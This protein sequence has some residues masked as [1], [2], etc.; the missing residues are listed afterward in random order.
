MK[1]GILTFQNAYNY[2]AVLQ[3][4]SLFSYLKGEFPD[5]EVEVL[6]YCS[7]KMLAYYSSSVIERIH[8][9][10]DS[11]NRKGIALKSKV[12]A[13]ELLNEAVNRK[14]ILFVRNRNQSINKGLEHVT[15]SEIKLLSSSCL[16][17]NATYSSKYDIIIVGSD[18]I[19]NDKQ[20][21]NPNV[22]L[23][24][25]LTCKYK[26]SFAASMYGMDYSDFD[27]ARK[28]Y[29]GEALSQFMYIGT[30]DQATHNYVKHMNADLEVFHNC[31]PS[32]L[33]DLKKLPIGIDQVLIKLEE[34]GID[35]SK[36]IIG[37][38]CDDWL[39]E[40]VTHYLGKKYQ[41]VALYEWNS[42]SDFYMDNLSPFEWA[43][44][45]SFF[46]ATFTHFFHGTMFSLKNGTLTF[47]I[48][49][50]S[51]Y[52]EKYMTKIKDALTRMDLLDCYFVLEKM[53]DSV[54]SHISM[55]TNIPDSTYLSNFRRKVSEGI[56][57]ERKTSESFLERIRNVI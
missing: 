15:Q 22:Y 5:A 46:R 36:P 19:W 40:R 43:L 26:M 37:L 27:E 17:F 45:F 2:G 52:S 39:A 14:K 42:F 31:D 20:V 41:Y 34:K 50:S 1:I 24:N 35:L 8:S 54:W 21:E 10:L 44:A 32:L 13:N 48:E 57:N 6:D 9:K 12:I 56:L 23:L 16:E 51:P 55:I 25:G 3:C 7:K 47:A 30:R 4:Y 29:V 38:M 53:D 18:A 33:I 11:I 49:K 28:E